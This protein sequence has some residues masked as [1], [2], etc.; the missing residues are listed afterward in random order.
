MQRPLTHLAMALIAGI[1]T[2]YCIPCSTLP[3]L[4]GLGFI[5]LHLLFAVRK[6]VKPLIL[7]LSAV[8]I[9]ILGMLSV[10]RSLYEIP[11][12]DHIVYQINAEKLTV[13]GIIDETPEESTEGTTIIVAVRDIVRENH[14]LPAKGRV[15]LS[16]IPINGTGDTDLRIDYP[17]K[18]GD[19]IRFK[20]RLRKPRN[21]NNPGGFDYE[22][23]LRGR[24]IL[25][26]GTINTASDIVLIRKGQGNRFKME[27]EK[28]RD[29]LRRII[30]E[31]SSPPEREII[32][33]LLL[34]ETKQIPPLLRENFNR[35]GTSHILAISGF[36]VAMVASFIIFLTL[37]VMK[38]SSYLLLR[39]NALRVAASV[40]L[41]PIVI[42][43]FIAGFGVSVTRATIMILIF[44]AGILMHKERDLFNTLALAAII[45]LLISPLALF[46][47]SFQLSFIAVASLIFVSP[48]LTQLTRG[49]TA[50]GIAKP[51]CL[52][53]RIVN[54][55]LIFILVTISATLGST[56]LIVYY[57]NGFPLVTLPANFLI[58]PLLGMVTFTMGMAVM[59]SL[60]LSSA[61]AAFLVKMTSIPAKLSIEA[62]NFFASL[63]GSYVN[64][65]TPSLP[66]IISFY[67]LL[68]IL[69]IIIR[70]KV[71]NKSAASG[72]A[73]R[74]PLFLKLALL[75]LI[76]FFIGDALYLAI[77]QNFRRHLEVTAIDVGQGS[78]TLIRLPAG[79]NILIDGG[80]SA[81]GSFNVGKYVVA[82]YLWRQRIT[83][84]EAVVLTHPHPDHLQ[85]LLYILEKFTVHEV[86]TTGY[87]A[88]DELYKNFLRLLK[89]KA[90]IHRIMGVETEPFRINGVAIDI[91]NPAQALNT[92][93]HT[94]NFHDTNDSSL[95]VRLTFGKI[96][97]LFPGDISGAIEKRII[98]EGRTVK[99]DVIFVA[100]HGGFTSSTLP[101][102]QAVKP[103]VAVVSCGK[104]NVFN[105]PHPDVLKRFE[106]LPA[107]ILRTD[108]NGAVSITTDGHELKITTVLGN[109]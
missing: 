99:S 42:Y 19:L 93:D 46:D 40:T 53:R 103:Q 30:T 36:N 95:A 21:F 96:S 27:I 101:F 49:E 88:E 98:A 59:I 75:A 82:P 77:G 102:L 12:A 41:M 60:P 72:K 83:E 100:H 64:I 26:R 90:C 6:G 45:I 81:S 105:L 61:L 22:K 25:V 8:A 13:E 85:G 52:A 5:F 78:A 28:A 23:H 44:L 35:T 18:Y 67:L 7:P 2:G 80:G 66:E 76:I 48:L 68:I 74:R 92:V 32:Q 1:V 11:K 14:L 55:L 65:S 17:L 71:E 16:L 29:K 104:D 63:P 86:W 58:V 31:N 3:L 39:F 69:V 57:F 50:E 54:Y 97:F 108:S 37:L 109:K 33:A 87:T 79:E 43:T 34:G 20:S 107:R 38:S 47:I 56:P 62:V 24:G 73:A 106:A 9:F 15:M 70:D 4:A 89:E 91:L 94:I 51:A 84:L 10:H